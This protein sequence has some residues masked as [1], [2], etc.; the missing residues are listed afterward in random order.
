M[1]VFDQSKVI[2]LLFFVSN[3]NDEPTTI[4]KIMPM[5]GNG[6]CGLTWLSG[7]RSFFGGGSCCNTLGVTTQNT[8]KSCLGHHAYVLMYVRRCKHK[9]LGIKND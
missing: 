8:S 2:F 6:V 9:F 5:V 3:S 1:V 4:G 7:F